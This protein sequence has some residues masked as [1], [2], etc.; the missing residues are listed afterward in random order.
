MVFHSPS[1]TSRGL[2]EQ[3]M[4][5]VAEWLDRGVTAARE[6]N[7]D[8]LHGIRAEVRELMAAYPAPGL[9]V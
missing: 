2:T 1:L 6:G 3:H 7:E 9:A 5:L 8:A 4:P